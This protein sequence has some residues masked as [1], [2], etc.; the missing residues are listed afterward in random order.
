M[1]QIGCLLYVRCLWVWLRPVAQ[2]CKNLGPTPPLGVDKNVPVFPW[3][4]LQAE[5]VA[6]SRVVAEYLISNYAPMLGIE[7][8][9][10]DA[11]CLQQGFA[12]ERNSV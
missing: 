4:V 2:T 10:Q 7:V 9:L 8:N 3:P 5:P 12:Q 11:A 1:R 6:K